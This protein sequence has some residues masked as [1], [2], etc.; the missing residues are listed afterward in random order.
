MNSPL[1]EMK[2]ITK[3]FPGVKAL[4]NISLSIYPSEIHALVGE[5]GAGKSTLIKILAG[6]Y[7]Y[8]QYQGKILL[9]DKEIKFKSVDDSEKSSIAVIHQELALEKYLTVAENIFLGN[10]PASFGLVDW[11]QMVSSSQQLIEQYGFNI[12]ARAEVYKLGIGDQQI[13]EIAKALRKNSRIL[14][15]D[16]PTAAL[17]ENETELLFEILVKLRKSGVTMIY[18]SHKLDEIFKIADRVTVFRDGKSIATGVISEWD[19]DKLIKSMVGRELKEIFPVVNVKT[20]KEVLKVER[21]SIENPESKGKF[22]LQDISFSSKEGEIVGISGLIGAGRSELLLSVFGVAPGIIRDGKISVENKEIK[23]LKDAVK[24]GVALIP[25]DR[26]NMGLVLGLPIV[27]NLSM[28]CLDDFINMG[29]IDSNEEFKECNVVYNQLSIKAFS[30]RA[31]VET[32]SGGNQQKIVF[33]KWLLNNPKLLLL[34]EPTRGVDVGA[35][36][37]I[38]QLINEL[39]KKGT[40]IIFVSSELPEVLG[41]SDRIIVIRR[42]KI[43]AEFKREEATQEKIMSAAA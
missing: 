19:K 34:D 38:Y 30:L 41:I 27:E 18:V 37:E 24:N 4:D 23:S 29:L 39:K 12:D 5:N 2:E 21:L 16:E 32:L 17:S 10:E 26:K 14:I 43:S 33:G 13:I 20:G 15:L 36:V 25:E 6:V 11:N 31:L 9:N 35:K 28:V 22:L 8:N 40:S 7:P 42:G 1:L 3:E